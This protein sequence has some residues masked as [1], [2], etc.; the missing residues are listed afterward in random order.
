MYTYLQTNNGTFTFRN[1]QVEKKKCLLKKSS[2]IF[3]SH[4]V[5]IWTNWQIIEML[6]VR[7]TL[8]LFIVD[9]HTHTDTHFP[10]SHIFLCFLDHSLARSFASSVHFCAR[11]FYCC[12][13]FIFSFD[14]S[15][16]SFSTHKLT[17]SL[18]NLF[19]HTYVEC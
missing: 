13:F 18:N 2:Y 19:I 16:H 4:P 14:N 7:S 5:C 3:T 1:K 9:T 12:S 17:H 11:L 10:R 6:F 8:W 15:F